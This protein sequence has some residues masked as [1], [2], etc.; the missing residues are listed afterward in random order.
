MTL[1]IRNKIKSYDFKMNRSFFTLARKLGGASDT[2][3]LFKLNIKLSFYS[4]I[5]LYLCFAEGRGT[6]LTFKEQ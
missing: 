4:N 1:L 5:K 2:Q 3:H 6:N